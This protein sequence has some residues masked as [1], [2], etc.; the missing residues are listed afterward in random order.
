MKYERNMITRGS[1]PQKIRRQTKRYMEKYN[2]GL[3][4]AFNIVCREY[5]EKGTELY[6]AWRT[7]DY[8]KFIPSAYFPESLDFEKYPLRYELTQKGEE[9]DYSRFN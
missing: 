4:D 8:R 6:A 3:Y 5:A 1:V 2:M 9:N 7:S